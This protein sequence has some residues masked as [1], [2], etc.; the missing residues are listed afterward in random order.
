MLLLPK[1]VEFVGSIVK[2]VLYESFTD[3]YEM[4][5]FATFI[6][7]CVPVVVEQYLSGYRLFPQQ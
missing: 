5:E 2:P 1:F 3:A 7:P 6:V 4:F